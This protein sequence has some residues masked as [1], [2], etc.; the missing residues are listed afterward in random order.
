M[1]DYT[2]TPNL[3]LY[4]P[5]YN[6]DTDQWGTHLNANADTLDS[7][8]AAIGTG[9]FLPIKG[10]ILTGALTLAGDPA[11]ALQPVT[12]QYYNA[13]LPAGGGAPTGPAGGDL[14]GSYP[15]PTL[16]T[17]A[18]T[19]GSYTNSNITVDAKGRI[20]AAGNGQAGTGGGIAEA[21]SDSQLY[22][23]FNATWAVV[24]ASAA[25][26]S[27]TPSMD[28]TATIGT[29][30]TYARADHI[31]P[32]DTSRYAASNP[33][34]YQTAA[35]V[36]TSLGPYALTSSVPVASSTNPAM[37]GTVAIGTGTTWARADHVH[38]SDTSRAPVS[39]PTFTAGV[40]ETRNTLAANNLD[41][42]TGS[43]FTKTVS[44]ATTLTVSNVPAAGTVASFLL[45]LTNGGSA[46]VTWWTGMK[47]AG[48]TA[49][50]LTA[51]GRDVLGFFTHDGGTTWSGLL[52]GKG[53]A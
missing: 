45:D 1:S 41:M 37:N 4:K 23:R 22:G 19:P 48:G 3:G 14:A 53:M 11:A 2:T 42:N 21:P 20:T 32:S 28:G 6:A 12:L 24:P 17:T 5:V 33:S 8:I 29:G 47:W 15:N 13:H 18:V 36:T 16:A 30:T 49:P 40:F 9:P 46:T 50:S 38:A 7:K 35:Q 44:G 43:V 25:P 52:L 51:A 27:T 31:H 26:S 10:G 39:N 34:G